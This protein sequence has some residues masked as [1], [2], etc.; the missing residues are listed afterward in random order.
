METTQTVQKLQAQID[1]MALEAEQA[2]DFG[3]HSYAE[4]VYLQISTLVRF[5]NELKKVKYLN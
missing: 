3:D 2:Y 1:K 4:S 5:Q